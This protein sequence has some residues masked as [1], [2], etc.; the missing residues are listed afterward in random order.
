[1]FSTSPTSPTALTLALRPASAAIRPITVPAPAMSHFMSSMPPAR[2]DADAAGVEGDALADEG[3][4]LGSPALP[5]PFQRITTMRGSLALPCATPSRAPKPSLRHLL[6]PQHLHFDAEVGELPAAFG[7]FGGVQH[8]RRLAHQVAGQEHAVGQPAER[9]PGG[10]V[11]PPARR[12]AASGW[13]AAACPR[14]SPWCGSG[15]SGRRAARRR[16]PNAAAWAGSS[17]S[18]ATAAAV[19]R[20]SAA[21]AVPPASSTRCGVRSA[22]LPRPTATTRVRPAPGARMVQV[23]PLRALELGGGQRAGDRAAGRLVRRRPQAGQRRPF[24]HRQ[25]ERAGARQGG[26]GEGDVEHG[27]ELPGG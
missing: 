7:E 9:R 6:R 2:L 5:A 20:A 26:G 15:R 24:G 11:P 27:G 3:D 23:L 4:R 18:A 22:G 1:M 16:A 14:A 17:P 13:R 8:V 12:R 10:R 25:D 21:A 19:S